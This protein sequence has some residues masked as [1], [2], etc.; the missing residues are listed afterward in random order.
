[1]YESWISVSD[2]AGAPDWRGQ[3]TR[4]GIAHV[5][6][7]KPFGIVSLAN[8]QFIHVQ[9]ISPTSGK[10][11]KVLQSAMH[12]IQ[13]FND[14]DDPQAFD[15]LGTFANLDVTPLFGGK[16]YHDDPVML[17]SDEITKAVYETYVAF[18]TLPVLK[19]ISIE[20]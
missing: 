12:P 10:P 9:G 2:V 20:K 4:L 3:W 16:D 8:A 19:V 5:T 15:S 6:Y 14:G 1:M 13:Y 17:V 11:Y 7:H 18:D